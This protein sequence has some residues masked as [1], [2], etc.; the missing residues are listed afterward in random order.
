MVCVVAC[1]VGALP[2]AAWN[3]AGHLL[4]ALVAYD[5]M[6]ADARAAAVELLSHHPR[7]REDFLERMPS[8]VAR[9]TAAERD[10]WLFAIASTWPDL[11]RTFENVPE[12]QRA[13]LV[14]RYN[15]PRWHFINQPVFLDDAER[16]A[17][18]PVAT[19]DALTLSP[20]TKEGAMNLVQALLHVQR[21]LAS[22]G[23]ASRR[24]VALCWLLHLAAD[25]HQPL[26]T[27]ALYTRAAFPDGDRGGN[28]ISIGERESL[29]GLWDGAA[30]RDRRWGSVLKAFASMPATSLPTEREPDFAAWARAGRELAARV[31]Y[32]PAIRDAVRRS[33][34]PPGSTVKADLPDGYA[35]AMRATGKRQIALAGV[36]TALVLEPL[37]GVTKKAA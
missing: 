26:H 23:S 20:G 27:V 14:A 5:R 29:H 28:L 13:P 21:T 17:L 15:H 12:A 33:T 1:V 16:D 8:S 6:S 25:L 9:G 32:A 2:A 11:T 3:D 35:A 19:N 22:G 10:R 24:A 30:A 4:A 37:L 34:L 36:R 7:Y 18:Q 31:V